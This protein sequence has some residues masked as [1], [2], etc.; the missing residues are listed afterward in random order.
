MANQLG[1]VFLTTVELERY[2][3]ELLDWAVRAVPRFLLAIGALVFGLWISKRLCEGIHKA[4]EKGGVAREL[5][6]FFGSIIDI[7][8]KITVVLFAASILGFETS[9]LLGLIAAIGFAI[10]MAM[11]GFLGN[12]ASGVTIIFF[13][14]YRVGDWVEISEKFGR[15]TDVHIFNTTILSPGSKT[16]VIPNGKVTDNIITN[17]STE[18]Q[19]KLEL[20]IGMPYQE[21]FPKVRDVLLE[22][23]R[24]SEYILLDPPPEVGILGYDSHTVTLVMRPTIEPDDYWEATFDVH[25]RVKAALS[26]A[27]IPMAYSEGVELGPIGG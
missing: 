9:S 14:P 6:S 25:A 4:L 22:A 20:E 19:L 10:G 2:A 24:G 11:Q 8:L 26:A 12:F 7:S 27:E 18:G 3:Q 16:L 15:V 1:Q 23:M 13:K 21:S 17:F 5:V